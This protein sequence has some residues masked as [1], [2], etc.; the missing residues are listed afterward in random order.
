[1]YYKVQG[2]IIKL[3]PHTADADKTTR[4][5]CLVRVCGVNYALRSQQDV[6]TAQIC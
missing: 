4:Q 2:Q 6:T 3:M 5:S 1:M